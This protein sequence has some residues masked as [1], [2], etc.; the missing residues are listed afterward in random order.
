MVLLRTTTVDQGQFRERI[1]TIES[2]RG[3]L[4]ENTV[5]RCQVLGRQCLVRE[6][7]SL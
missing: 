1:I 3:T 6:R 7:H 4:V 5:I 2:H